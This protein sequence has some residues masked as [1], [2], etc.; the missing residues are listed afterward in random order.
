MSLVRQKQRYG[1]AKARI[2]GDAGGDLLPSS[3]RHFVVARASAI[4][5]IASARAA[6]IDAGGG[7]AESRGSRV[8]VKGR[9][10]GG[11]RFSCGVPRV[12][13]VAGAGAAATCRKILDGPWATCS[14]PS[15]VSHARTGRSYQRVSA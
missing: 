8:I 2:G 3:L 1:H 11:V 7:A 6:A 14:V 15:R 12:Y 4:F 5:S 10:R 9:P 13:S